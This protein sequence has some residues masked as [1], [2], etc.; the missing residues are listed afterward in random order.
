MGKAKT[1]RQRAWARLWGASRDLAQVPAPGHRP[2]P[3]HDGLAVGLKA[4]DLCLVRHLPAHGR[5]SLKSGALTTFLC[6]GY[7][8][9][10]EPAIQLFLHSDSVGID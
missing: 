10:T 3:A 5:G 2:A 8:H 1:L 9:R 4:P 6:P 7:A